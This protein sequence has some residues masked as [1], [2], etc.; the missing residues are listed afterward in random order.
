M[1]LTNYIINDLKPYDIGASL[2]TIKKAF[3]QLTYSHIPVMKDG[4]YMGCISETDAH[5]F[6]ATKTIE[7]VAY[8]VES[9]FVRAH[10]NWLD[11]LEAFA[12][13]ACNIMPVLNEDN[14]YLGYYELSDIMNLFNETPF[15]SE[16]GAIIVIE[17]NSRD[18]SFSEICQIVES[19]DGKLLG[20]F[21][22]KIDNDITQATI[23]IG[24]LGLNAITQTFRRYGYI[25]VSEH[26]EDKLQEE[27][28]E[29]SQYLTKYLNI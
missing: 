24:H 16:A 2:A 27:L 22:S 10:T 17:K 7:E 3:N 6:E 20:A 19:N 14:K 9:I 1:N 18:Y 15:L 26:E 29:R 28:K 11:V 13:N 12:Q 5:C 21:I 25:V 8:A 4:V 23:K